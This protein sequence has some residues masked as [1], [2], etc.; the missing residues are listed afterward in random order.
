MFTSMSRP[1]SSLLSAN[2]ATLESSTSRAF[3]IAMSLPQPVTANT[4]L[5]RPG[6]Y[7]PSSCGH[8]VAR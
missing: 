8:C 1:S 7:Q 6:G 5:L 4:W 3:L 2:L